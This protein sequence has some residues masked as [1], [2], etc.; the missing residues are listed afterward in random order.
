MVKI[1]SPSFRRKAIDWIPSRLLHDVRD[2]VDVMD[3]TSREIYEKKKA[4]FVD[5]DEAVMNQVGRGKDIMSLLR[6]F[7][8]LDLVA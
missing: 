2:I 7:L 3:A 5:G 6:A 8:C 1:G 4:A